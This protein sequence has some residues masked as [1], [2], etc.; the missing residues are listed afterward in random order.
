MKKVKKNYE[1]DLYFEDMDDD[2]GTELMDL[3]FVLLRRWKLIGNRKLQ[4][5]YKEPVIPKKTGRKKH[6]NKLTEPVF[7]RYYFFIQ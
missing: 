3:I 5:A 7:Q 1:E 6:T 4:E 2:D